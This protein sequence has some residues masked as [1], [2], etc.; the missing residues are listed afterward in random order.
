MVFFI[1][2]SKVVNWAIILFKFLFCY[3]FWIIGTW[4]FL[5]NDLFCCSNRLFSIQNS[6]NFWS[7]FSWHFF[8]LLF[9]ELNFW[10]EILQW[11]YWCSKRSMNW[12]RL[13]FSLSNRCNWSCFQTLFALN[14]VQALISK[15]SI[16]KL[17]IC[18]I[19]LSMTDC[20]CVR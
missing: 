5:A 14:L 7:L 9:F 12:I 1:I 19:V 3:F 18:I 16:N 13:D 2:L 8:S 10:V 11:Y 4:E 20:R 17:E 15:I 6:F